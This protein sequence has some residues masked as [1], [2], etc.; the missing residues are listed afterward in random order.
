MPLG[1]QPPP[2]LPFAVTMS[3]LKVTLQHFKM[4]SHIFWEA[5]CPVKNCNPEKVTNNS[6]ISGGLLN[7]IYLYSHVSS[8][9]P[10]N[11]WAEYTTADQE[12]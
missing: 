8:K 11:V 1:K 3:L 9:D 12:L 2:N 7:K 6:N 5:H 10:Y 4:N